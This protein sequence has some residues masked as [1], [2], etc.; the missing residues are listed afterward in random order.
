MCKCSALRFVQV[1]RSNA[2][3]Y[4]VVVGALRCRILE[5]ERGVAVVAASGSMTQGSQVRE[6]GERVSAEMQAC[7]VL[8][9]VHSVSLVGDASEVTSRR[10][11]DSRRSSGFEGQVWL[12]RLGLILELHLGDGNA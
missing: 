2:E 10:R 12:G 3:N 11:A 4:E 5:L 6:V 9:F 8:D 1:A 7:S